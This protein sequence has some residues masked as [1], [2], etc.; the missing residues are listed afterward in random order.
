ML[1]HLGR[2]ANYAS[3]CSDTRC[4]VY[5]SNSVINAVH[6]VD[7][8]FVCI[9]LGIGVEKEGNDRPDMELP[10]KQK[11]LLQD[12]IDNSGAAKIILI[13]FNAGP[14]NIQ[15]LDQSSR[16]SAILAVFYPGQ[17]TGVAL[18]NALT[19][20]NNPQFGRLPYTWYK[21]ANQVPPM[22]DYSMSGRTYRYFNGEPLYPFGYGLTYTT[23]QYEHPVIPANI[24]AG[25]DLHGSVVVRNTGSLPGDEVVQVYISWLQ[26]STPSPQLQLVWFDRVTIGGNGQM[27]VHFS[28]TSKQMALWI[29]NTGWK[30]EAGK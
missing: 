15:W 2:K 6:G 9:G 28:V 14:V 21:S 18:R 25:R 23:F 24:K 10:G 19:N 16:V 22:I 27:T 20:P 29:D 4:D 30:I 3:G 13:S 7:V 12:V 5:D 11:Q 26:S 8:V 1:Q 17:S